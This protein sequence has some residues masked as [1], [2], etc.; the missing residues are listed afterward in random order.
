MALARFENGAIGTIEGTRMAPGRKNAN[1]FEINGSAGTIAF[2]LE[3][4]NELEVYIEAEDASV[5]GFHRILATE[6]EHPFVKSWWPPGHIIGYEHT[7]VHTVYDLLEAIADKRLPSPNFHDGL[8]NQLVHRGDRRILGDETMGD[9]MKL[10]VFTVL[11]GSKPFEE[12]LGLRRRSRAGGRRNRH[13]RVSWQRVLPSGGTARERK[14]LRVFKDAIS[15]RG[16]VISA[17]S[18]H[19]N[20]LHPQRERAAADHG[21]FVKTLELAQAARSRDRDHLQRMSRWRSA[22]VAAELDRLTL[23]TR[24]LRD[25]RVAVAR[26]R[27]ALLERAPARSRTPPACVSPSRCIR[28]SLPT[29]P[30]R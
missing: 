13:R 22:G 5:R 7:F 11:F 3:R 17:L 2:D 4:L 18:C 21:V 19:G 30:S 24:V 25:A 6:P 14:Q 20:P 10:G 28:T 8:R 12:V 9:S 15:R 29:T 23:A 1:R 26:A 16:L 27:G